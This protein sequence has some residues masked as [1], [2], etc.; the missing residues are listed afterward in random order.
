MRRW[1]LFLLPG[2]LV[3]CAAPRQ[4]TRDVP[5][6]PPGPRKVEVHGHRG[7]RALRPE[8]T[9][10]GFDFALK[11][12]ADVLEMDLA[13]T[14]DDRLVVIHDLWVPRDLCLGPDGQPPPEGLAI[15]SLTLGEVRAFDCGS[16]A[17]PRFPGQQAVPGQRIPTLE[18]VLSLA[19]IAGVFRDV[20]VR[21]NLELKTVPGRPDLGPDPDRLAALLAEAIRSSPVRW[22]VTVQCFD[23]RVLRAFHAR[24][25]E[26]PL[27]ALLDQDRPV[28]LVAV[29]RDARASIL[30]PHHQWITAS[31]V[32]VLHQAGIRV[33][34]WTAN[35]P[36]DWDRLLEMAV[37]G[38]ITDDPGGLFE[39]LRS[40]GLR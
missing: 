10:A 37:D 32:R 23:H 15:R 13:V 38:I 9:L 18:E 39:H 35:D 24:M 5:G 7:A 33:I 25:P 27:A 29:A 8:N 12:G 30:S 6:P 16:R 26:V 4:V 36:R 14:R 34:P 40:R 22:Q 3:Q 11:A 1:P 2:I 19:R 17:N 21:L 31:D 20:P 28:D